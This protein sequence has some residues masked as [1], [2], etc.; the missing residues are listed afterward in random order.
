[1]FVNMH[2]SMPSSLMLPEVGDLGE[3]V[4]DADAEARVDAVADAPPESEVSLKALSPP[5]VSITTMS[6]LA[7]NQLK[8]I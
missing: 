1:M 4:Y 7:M 5:S 6:G 3:A 2:E 8:F